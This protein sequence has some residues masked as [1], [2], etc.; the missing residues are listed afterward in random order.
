[1]LNM[2]KN[3]M[4]KNMMGDHADDVEKLLDDPKTV[5]QMSGFW[6]HLD[7]MSSSDKKGYDE[8]IKK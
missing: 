1:M 8:Y 2:M 6:K 5:Q 7:E 3:P 4:F